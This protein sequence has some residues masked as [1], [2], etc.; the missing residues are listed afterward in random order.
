MIILEHDAVI[1]ASLPNID[2]TQGI[3]K[4][5]KSHSVRQNSITGTWSKGAYGYALSP[6]HAD[7]LIKGCRLYG[8]QALDKMI[9]SNIVPWG[10]LDQDLITLPNKMWSTT[11]PKRKVI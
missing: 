2:L 6:S 3:V 10:F 8:A 11:S 5:F 9:G 4:L 1:Q 7:L